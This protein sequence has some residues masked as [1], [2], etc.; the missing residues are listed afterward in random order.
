MTPSLFELSC[1]VPNGQT[2]VSA[3]ALIS[4]L[5][6]RDAFL[7]VD[8][9]GALLSSI[10]AQPWLGELERRVQHYG[11]KYDYRSRRIDA[12]MRVGHLPPWM[13]T[14]AEQLHKEGW[15]ESVPDQVIVNE[16]EPGQ[17]IVPH[18]DC[19]PCFGE[20]IV[21]I[22][23]GS[24]TVMD[25]TNAI[26]EE[27]LPVWLAPRSAVVLRAQAR[28]QWKHGIAKRKKDIVDGV[29]MTRGRRV[30]L[31]FRNVIL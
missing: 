12:S 14:V 23:M 8:Q 2:N 15:F 4:G 26:T 17:G 3:L 21:S 31:T 13:Q 18:I 1:D 24:G 10:N 7:S 6:V 30:S 11:Y 22:S 9:E 20:T 5:E 27:H 16:H 19:E 25:F 28:H 29:S